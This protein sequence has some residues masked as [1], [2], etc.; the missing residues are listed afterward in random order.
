MW[1]VENCTLIIYSTVGTTSAHHIS[2]CDALY[3]VMKINQRNL[4]P[5]QEELNQSEGM[6][7]YNG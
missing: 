3:S 1:R 2:Y 5:S 7:L 6:Q 4:R